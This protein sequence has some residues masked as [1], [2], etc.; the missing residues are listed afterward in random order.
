MTRRTVY[1]ICF[2]IWIMIATV[3]LASAWLKVEIGE[4]RGFFGAWSDLISSVL[5][6]IVAA[7][8]IPELKK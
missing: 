3:N 2:Y 7:F 1:T 5:T 4:V 8:Y 6:L